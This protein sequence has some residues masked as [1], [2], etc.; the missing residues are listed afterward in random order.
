MLTTLYIVNSIK[1]YID[2]TFVALYYTN[3]NLGRYFKEE[4]TECESHSKYDAMD[5]Q[6]VDS[7]IDEV[8]EE[9]VF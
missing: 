9:N 7:W 3:V 5:E 4:R 6:H 1:L 8:T 2:N